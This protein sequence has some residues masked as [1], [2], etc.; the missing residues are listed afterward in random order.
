MLFYFMKAI[1]QINRDL[2]FQLNK[3]LFISGYSQGGHST[4]ALHKKLQQEYSSEYEVTASSP[5]SGPYDISD[6]QDKVMFDFYTQPHY[7]P[8]LLISYN[9]VYDIFPKDSFYNIFKEPIIC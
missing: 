6:T 1:K 8:Y 4:L 2:N 3:Q 5:M 9:E 7:L